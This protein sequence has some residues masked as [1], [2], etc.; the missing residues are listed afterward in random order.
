MTAKTARCWMLNAPNDLAL[1][2]QAVPPPRPD[3]VIVRVERAT[4]LSYMDR[5]IDGSLRYALPPFPFTPGTNA[6][7]RVEAIGA[8]VGHVTEGARVFLSPHLTASQP[9]REPSQILIG[10][11]AMGADSGGKLP[12]AI[13][14][15]QAD[16]RN[17]V[18]G[19]FAHWPA[20]CV[21][22]L[23]RLDARP[24]SEVIGLAKAMVPFGGLLRS[25]LH[26]GETIIV[27]GATGYFGSAGVLVALAMGAGRVVAAGRN[28]SALNELAALHPRIAP[29]VLTGDETSDR[30]ALMG[31]T[32]GCADR[33][34]DM[35]GQATSTATTSAV[36]RTLRRGGRLVLMGSATAPLAIGF[37]EMLANDWE[38]V[39]C[40][41][42]P[43]D[44]PARLAALLASGL[45]DLRPL[46]VSSYRLEELPEAIAAASKMRDLDCVTIAP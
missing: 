34:L 27:N 7:G 36:L 33:A 30:A 46:R 35:L 19:T 42:Y 11:T 18:F 13:Q 1:V 39:G 16:W 21:T 26:A 38:V 28:A 29:A 45:L 6:I 24:S 41:M 31:A 43:R 9:G 12:P 25:G 14:R 20:S 32:G 40:F 4:V 44:A 2:E 37:G 15:M 17:G 10:L 8:E 5:I 3:G 23:A 22:P